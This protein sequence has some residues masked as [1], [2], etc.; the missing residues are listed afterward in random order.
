MA[1]EKVDTLQQ[2]RAEQLPPQ[3]RKHLRIACRLPRRRQS[4][5]YLNPAISLVYGCSG[6]YESIFRLTFS[7]AAHM[8]L[9][10]TRVSKGSMT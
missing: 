6:R 5:K 8:C 1:V 3:C 7:P 2:Q 9:M 4:K 10:Y